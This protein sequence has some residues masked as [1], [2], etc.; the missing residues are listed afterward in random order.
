M[1]RASHGQPK[2]GSDCDLILKALLQ[3]QR[4]TNFKPYKDAQP[5]SDLG[6]LNGKGRIADLRNIYGWTQIVTEK[7]KVPKRGNKETK[8]A[9]YS[10]PPESRLTSLESKQPQKS[11]NYP[12]TAK[13]FYQPLE[14]HLDKDKLIP[15]LKAYFLQGKN[16]IDAAKE[17]GISQAS[18]TRACQE[19]GIKL[20]DKSKL[21]IPDTVAYFEAI[22]SLK[23]YERS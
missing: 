15:A 14:L 16:S 7:V 20:R 13:G 23:E 9:I 11:R 6:C 1:T 18:F 19:F 17:I 5:I 3:G 2:L 21:P 12:R 22:E 4:L 10:I 8:I